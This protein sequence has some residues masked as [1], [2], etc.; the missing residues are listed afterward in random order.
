MFGIRSLTCMKGIR[1]QSLRNFERLVSRAMHLL[2]LVTAPWGLWIGV[3]TLVT[4]SIT[5]EGV[6]A[7]CFR[8]CGELLLI[9]LLAGAN[10]KIFWRENRW[11][12]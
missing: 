1:M 3:A 2:A 11:K 7:F 9:A 12:L 4:A 6:Q 8:R 5:P 10:A